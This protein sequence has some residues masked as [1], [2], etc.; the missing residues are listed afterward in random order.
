MPLPLLALLA[1]GA[2]GV[3]AGGKII[4]DIRRSGKPRNPL[5]DLPDADVIDPGPDNAFLS[6]LDSIGKPGKAIND[7]LVGNWEGAGRQAVDFLGDI[8]D[9]PLLGVDAI[10]PISRRK[11]KADFSDVVG[12]MEPGLGKFATDVIGGTATDPL[13]WVPGELV[14]KGASTAAKAAGKVASKLPKGLQKWGKEIGEGAKDALGWRQLTPEQNG[15]IRAAEADAVNVKRAGQTQLESIGKTVVSPEERKIVGDI[16]DNLR[17][18]GGKPV[19]PIGPPGSTALDRVNLHP[20]VNP[21]NADRITKAVRETIEFGQRQGAQDRALGIMDDAGD[22]NQEYLMQI[23]NGDKAVR[24]S[25]NLKNLG[26]PNPV[27]GRKLITPEDKASFYASPESAGLEYERNAVSRLGKRI[28]K[29]STLARQA[30]LGKSLLGPE[31]KSLRDPETRT[32]IESAIGAFEQTAPDY[33]RAL[34]DVYHGLEPRGPV[35]EMFSKANR[36]WKPM[37]V[38]GFVWPKFSA[39]VRNATTGGG[40]QVASTQGFKAASRHMLEAPGIILGAIDDGIVKAFGLSKR[41]TGG[42]LTK[43]VDAIEQAFQA[44]GGVVENAKAILRQT[45]REDLAAAVENNV[46]QGM[47]SSEEMLRSINREGWRKAAMNLIDAPGE[48]YQGIETR[49]RLANFLHQYHGQG[50]KSARQIAQS[51]DDAFLNYGVAAQGGKAYRTFRDNIPFFAFMSQS[52][53]QQAKF[54]TKT[55]PVA[56]GLSQAYD[57]DPGHPLYGYLEGRMNLPIGT[58]EA[59]EREYISGLGMPFEQLGLI[60]NFSDSPLDAG[61]DIKRNFIGSSQPIAKSAATAIMGSDPYWESPAGQYDKIPLFGEQG[62]IGQVYNALNAVGITAPFDVPARQLD[63]LLNPDRSVGVKAL[64][65]LTGANIVDVDEDR[66][67]LQQ[68]QTLLEHNPDVG[69]YRSFFNLSDDPEIQALL[70]RYQGAKKKAKAS[71]SQPKQ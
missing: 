56:V 67:L 22:L 52:I 9:A 40:W 39:L 66:A 31:Y 63:K 17:H 68:L 30:S 69:Q 32:A 8:V 27:R 14:A 55:P 61:R 49:M 51:V 48:M 7:L 10:A 54:L 71:Q 58:N 18:E 28:D 19:G 4:G 1:L 46:L 37:V 38:A 26:G 24:D 6:F 57:E 12:G 2:G 64:D 16:V 42:M 3:A 5:D 70:S 29:D 36:L 53:P 13:S 33:Y 15:V 59:G 44:S 11:D 35:L 47:V 50:G 25:E 45:G 62:D 41:L 21:G 20:G 43:D 65:L 60:P 34:N 23:H